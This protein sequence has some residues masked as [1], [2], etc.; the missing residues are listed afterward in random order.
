ME[1]LQSLTR[2]LEVG[3][4]I[5]SLVRNMKA[6][7]SASIRHYEEAARSLERYA[8]AVELGLQIALRERRPLP[9][10]G[11]STRPSRGLVVFGSSLGLAGRFNERVT[12]F[13]SPFFEGRSVEGD[14]ESPGELFDGAPRSLRVL[15]LG[16]YL[17]RRF[18]TLREQSG[19]AVA[20]CELSELPLPTSLANLG[21][22]VHDVL[23][24]VESW[25]RG[26]EVG[27]ITLCYNAR[28]PDAPFAPRAVRLLPLDPAWLRELRRRPWPTRHLPMHTMA[29]KPLVSALVREHLF[30]TLY[31]AFAESL[32][33]EQNHRLVSMQA[34]EHNIEERLDTL[35]HDYHERRQAQITEELLDIVSGWEV[36]SAGDDPYGSAGP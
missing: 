6:L 8:E 34:A 24:E 1:T 29:W 17:R 18:E 36:M 13:V 23:E 21:A 28:S 9:E 33:A 4:T 12:S 11:P 3:E 26:G 7:A 10:E 35:R 31:R 15:L 32:A 14:A 20:R 19:P 27:E 5:H 25:H 2:R 30:V 16:G 22:G